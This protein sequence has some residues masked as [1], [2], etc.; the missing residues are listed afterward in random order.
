MTSSDDP[1]F[2]KTAADLRR[3][4]GEC[5]DEMKFVYDYGGK[6]TSKTT[7]PPGTFVISTFL[8][9]GRMNENYYSRFEELWGNLSDHYASISAEA[10]FPSTID[11]ANKKSARTYYYSSCGYIETLKAEADAAKVS[12][13]GV[14]TIQNQTVGGSGMR[15]K[16]LP[17]IQLPSF[18]GELINWPKFR[19]TYQSLVHSEESLSPMEKFHYLRTAL[20]GCALSVI[21]HL[22][23]EEANY[24]L[25][26]K[27]VIDT[28][29]NKRMLASAYLDQL[30]NFKPIQGTATAESLRVFLA[31]IADNV[32]AFNLLNITDKAE[33]I[34][35]HLAIRCL[36]PSTRDLFEMSHKDVQFPTIELLSKFVRER[37]LALQLV[38]NINPMAHSSN[39][40]KTYNHETSKSSFPKPKTPKTKSLLVENKRAPERK[41]S[42][43]Y[44]TCI[45][46]K[47][48]QHH[49]L[50][51]QQF[52]QA[53]TDQ[54]WNLLKGFTGCFNCLDPLHTVQACK[55]K[56]H[57]RFCPKRHHSSLH[58]TP[59]NPNTSLSTLVHTPSP[60][61]QATTSM[62]LNSATPNVEHII[63]G[64]AIAEVMDARGQFQ[65]IRIVIDSG[66]QNSFVTHK[67]FNKLG[68]TMTKAQ[69]KISGIGQ[70]IFE[71]A[72]GMSTCIIKP[73]N[74]NHPQLKT[75]V[76]VVSSITSYL[77]SV[78]LPMEVVSMVK[79][80]T[81][82]DPCFW[83]PGP[84]DFLLGADLFPE[85]WTGS[86][87]TIQEN[88]PRL[89]SS[90]FG[91][92]VIGKVGGLSDTP[93]STSLFTMETRD[94]LNFQLQRFWEIEEPLS[95][96]HSIDPDAVRCEEHFQDTHHRMPD[97]RYVVRLP[98]RDDIVQLGDSSG[99]ALRR[100]FNLEKKLSRDPAIQEK[101]HK[102]MHEYL[103]LDHMAVSSTPSKFVI[104]HHSVVKQDHNDIKLR[105][106]FDASVKV[107]NGSLNQHLL[108]GE[109]LQSNI[110]EVLLRFRRHKVAFTTDIVKMFRMILVDPQDRKYQ[111]IFWRFSEDEE[112][113]T[114]ELKTVTYG[115][116]CAPFQALR[117]LRQLVADHGSEFPLAAQ[118]L[119]SN[120]YVDDIL[121]GADSLQSALE[122]QQQTISLL[123]KGCFHLSKWAS[124]STAI[125]SAV[126]EHSTSDPV[127]LAS[128]EDTWVNILG[129]QWDPAKDTFQFTITPPAPIFT[130]RGILSTVA[131]LYDPLGFLTPTILLMK[132]FIQ[133]LWKLSL[134][135]DDT[136]PSHI[137]ENWSSILEEFPMIAGIQIPRY[138]HTT[139]S[140]EFQV[141][142]FADASQKGYA[143]VIYLRVRKDDSWVPNLL[144][145]KSKLAPTKTMS[146]PRLELSAAWLLAQLYSSLS[147]FLSSISS[148][149]R[150]PVF[151]TDS[152]ITLGWINSPSYNLKVFVANR[153]SKIQE[154]TD[155]SAWKHVASEENPSDVASRGIMPS[156]LAQQSLWWSGPSWLQLN[157][158]Y[159]PHSAINFPPILP[160]VK[161]APA[162]L[163]TTEVM[164]DPIILWMGRFSSYYTLIRA[165]AWIQRWLYNCKHVG[166]CCCP[167]RTGNLKR[168]E[169]EEGFRFCIKKVQQQYLQ[170]P[171]VDFVK[172][173]YADLRPYCDDQGIWRV[174]GRLR[175][176][177]LQDTQKHPILLPRQCHLSDILV[178]Y[179][180]QTY[181]HPGPN[182]LQAIIQRRFWIPSLR[183]LIRHRG[184]HC[185]RCFKSKAK[186]LTP[187][188]GD[189]PSY[190]VI[191]GRAF[192]HVGIDFAGPFALKESQRRKAALGKAYLCLYVC[193]ATKAIHL[194]VVS[195][196]TTDAFLA[197]FQRFTARRG[198]PSDV[199]TD[200]GSNFLGASSYLKELFQWLVSGETTQE[201]QDYAMKTTFNWHF[202]P[203][204]TP[205]MGGIWEAG[206]KS[207]KT[208]LRL[209]VGDTALTFEELA[210]VFSKLKPC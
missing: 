82:A 189:L 190:R 101:Y 130:K 171:S 149:M 143:A 33:F 70:T 87:V 148:H 205:H 194:E 47:S 186:A 193:M 9:M 204:Q 69:R 110:R 91:H 16:G 192:L 196:L 117:V 90:I 13:A 102:F 17:K 183:R 94:D 86:V 199:Y 68:L 38:S 109:K 1:A 58:R 176:S 46:C 128:D 98:F 35:F 195:R 126:S 145:A 4:I 54:K 133:E 174:G 55:S 24:E 67:C 116:A 175:H 78:P 202:N 208:H 103:V 29:D 52:H 60:V 72:K 137:K 97:G 203:P 132:S 155:V 25:A 7:P 157:E 207:V 166:C 188:M 154:L 160:E 122:V 8:G 141:V 118:V 172:T 191:G 42:V 5:L 121:A 34:L 168:F 96:Q 197:C 144:I 209:T 77:P 180:H 108:V 127:T 163:V 85:I 36:D 6:A 136:V 75:E 3:K 15:S 48:E 88:L 104:P 43:A 177:N 63:L 61:T 169:F 152:S 165:A 185:N 113:Q 12:V 19:D 22:V 167:M 170:G 14:S 161:E 162:S 66:S 53:S 31:K 11:K 111:R 30:L 28:Y 73:R 40:N 150:N 120:I 45:V 76:L 81:L 153:V 26:W 64:T 49:L 164:I 106:V 124:N 18:D 119:Q 129:L 80:F 146:I 27:A 125:L 83:K 105:V 114:F 57:C 140:T 131:R 135:W 56:W 39:S 112:V 179:Y 173:K 79:G 158:E 99:V 206:V 44:P 65:S 71:G 182:T 187:L 74:S 84:I 50:S 20:R 95:P 210:T 198:L 37:S 138:L 89:F 147:E 107:Q 23:L 200:C 59:V 32:S 93:S 181:L 41:A 2:Q 51:C 184:F 115:L 21:T 10:E 62:S 178:D 156:Q 134:D 123:E 92:I 100:F 151:F 142:G 159:W 139:A 201:L